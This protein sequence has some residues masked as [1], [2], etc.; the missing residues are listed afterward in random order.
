MLL[1]SSSAV[2][3]RPGVIQSLFIPVV[4]ALA[5]TTKLLPWTTAVKNT[6]VKQREVGVT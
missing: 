1:L 2:G 6:R 4:N 3:G 5:N